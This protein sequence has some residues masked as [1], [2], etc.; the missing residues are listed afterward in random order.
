M[1]NEVFVLSEGE[2]IGFDSAIPHG[3][4]N[5]GDVDFQGVW[6]VHGSHH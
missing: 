3:M 4:R 1:G 5:T 2:S 6:F